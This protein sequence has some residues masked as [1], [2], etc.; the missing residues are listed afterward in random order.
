[1]RKELYQA[2]RDALGRIDRPQPIAHIDLWNQHMSFLEQEVPFRLPAVFIE[3]S[4]TDWL[5]VDNGVYKTNQE[6]RLHIVTEWPGADVAEEGLGEVFDLIDEVTWALHNLCGQSFRAL[7]RVAS[8]TNHD[9][10]ELIDMVE[11]Y[12]CVAYDEFVKTRSRE[13]DGKEGERP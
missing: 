2:I 7:Q 13:L 3:F 1:M 5:H 9:H 12:R 8:E 4:P 6:V 10:E 11:T